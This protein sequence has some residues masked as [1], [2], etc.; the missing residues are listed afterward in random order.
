MEAMARTNPGNVQNLVLLGSAYMQMQ[1]SD[2][3]VELF[4]T[5]LA[6][7]EIQLGEAQAIAQYLEQL[8]NLPKLEIAIEKMASL[9]P[10]QPEPRY[11][12]AVL[13]TVEGDQTRAL[14]NLKRALELSARRL[15]ND[16]KA[17]DLLATARTDS[18]LD[19]LR[20]LPEFQKLVPAK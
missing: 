12:L 19:R 6:R 10:D 14:E 15:A 16:P 2:H 5:A 7:P 18:R 20:A 3:A 1:Q 9:A 11:S 13:Q 17:I 4:N 8:G